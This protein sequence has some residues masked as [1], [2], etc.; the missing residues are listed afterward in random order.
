[1]S[2][3]IT[4][5]SSHFPKKEYLRINDSERIQLAELLEFTTEPNLTTERVRERGSGIG[6]GT[7]SK[8]IRR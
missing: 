3:L 7:E 1:M 4:I 5:S 2:N 8:K 6:N